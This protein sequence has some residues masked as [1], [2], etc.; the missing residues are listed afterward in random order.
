MLANNLDTVAIVVGAVALAWVA[1]SV[2]ALIAATGTG[3]LTGAV[4]ALGA[5]ILANPIGL[6]AIALIALVAGLVI[7]YR[8]VGWFRN[9]IRRALGR[10]QN[11]VRLDQISLAADPLDSHRP[12]RRGRSIYVVRHWREVLDF[13]KGLPGKISSAASGMWDGIKNAFR[14]GHQLDH[15]MVERARVQGAR[16]RQGP[17]PY[18]RV[19]ARGARPADARLGRHD[20]LGRRRDRRRGRA[21]ARHAAGRRRRHAVSARRST[22]TST[23]TAAKSRPPSATPP[24]TERRA[25]N[26]R[27]SS[28]PAPLPDRE[29]ARPAAAGARPRRRAR[30][31][32]RARA[33]LLRRPAAVARRACSG[34][35]RSN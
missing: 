4:A 21:R 11:R 18:R 34:P 2:G 29:H 28:R 19:H 25:A 22:R 3:T 12:V 27:P 26:G 9:G 7:A 30:P 24:P 6:I 15:R 32:A 31:A 1:W 17:H 5:A 16:H 23:S 20:H 8:K 10:D 33:D 13:V 35:T 14:S